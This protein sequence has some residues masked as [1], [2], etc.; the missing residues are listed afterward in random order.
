MIRTWR[1]LA[2]AGIVALLAFSIMRFG[3]IGWSYILGV[4]IVPWDKILVEG[5]EGVNVIY[6][7]RRKLHSV[8]KKQ[9]EVEQL[10]TLAK[11]RTDGRSGDA[12]NL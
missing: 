11:V 8:K 5:G 6:C 2:L 10:E 12:K 4:L 7:W 9:S 3:D 1:E